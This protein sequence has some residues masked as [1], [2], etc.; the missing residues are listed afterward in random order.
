MV[1]YKVVEILPDLPFREI[2][3]AHWLT[4]RLD[5]RKGKTHHAAG[6]FSALE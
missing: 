2:R 1:N 3:E 5:L 4:F 6:W